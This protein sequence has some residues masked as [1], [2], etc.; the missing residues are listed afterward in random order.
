MAAF[1]F[2]GSLSHERN[3]S[4]WRQW[5]AARGGQR[6]DRPCA[7]SQWLLRVFPS[8]LIGSGQLVQ[9]RVSLSAV[10]AL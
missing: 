9:H 5:W 1:T 7:T 8:R 3:A 6:L 4:R 10:A 2:S